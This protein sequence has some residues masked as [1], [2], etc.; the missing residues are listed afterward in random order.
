MQVIAVV[1]Y[2]IGASQQQEQM[3]ANVDAVEEP[4]M[5]FPLVPDEPQEAA[6]PVVP[7]VVALGQSVAHYDYCPGSTF[8]LA[9]SQGPLPL[10]INT[11]TP[12]ALIT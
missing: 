4:A 12:P 9:L 10:Y 1:G 7:H 5:M 2:K 11:R 6:E 3:V 8:L